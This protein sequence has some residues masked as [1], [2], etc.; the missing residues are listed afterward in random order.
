M[1]SHVKMFVTMRY[2]HNMKRSII[3]MSAHEVSIIEMKAHIPLVVSIVLVHINWYS[4]HDC[5]LMYN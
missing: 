5:I 4:I 2:L 1:P 3:E